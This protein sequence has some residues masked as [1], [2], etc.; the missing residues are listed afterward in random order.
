MNVSFY[1][2]TER[3]SK[4]N[5]QIPIAILVTHDGWVV[6][7]NLPKLKTKLEDWDNSQYRIVPSKRGEPNNLAAEYNLEIDR[8]KSRLSEYWGNSIIQKTKITPDVV[9]DIITG[10]IKDKLVK[11]EPTLILSFDSFIEQN[12]S[13]RAERTITGYNTTK[14]LLE[15]FVDENKID[16]RLSKL[17]MAFYDK[18]RNYCFQDKGYMNN[19]FAKITNNLKAFMSWA[20]D[21]D[22]HQNVIYHKFKANE[23]NIEVIYLTKEELFHLNS[24]E[25][26]IDRLSRA[27]DIYCF[28]C[29]TGLRY[30][31]LANLKP[32]NIFDDHLKIN[33][34]KTRE[35]DQ[36]IPLSK[37]AKQI[38]EKYKY[39]IHYPLP[40]ISSQKLNEYIKDACEEAEINT[41]VTITR[42]SGK[43]KI[44]KTVPKY[45]LLTLHT[46]R[47]TFVT[48]SLVLGMNQMI[49]RGITGH[50]SDSAFRKYVKVA[51]DVK[52]SEVSKYWD[53]I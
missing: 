10:K 19:T 16:E 28:S 6:R 27:R 5:G 31:D 50:K 17:D 47:K 53:N 4:K 2:R 12:K 9:I 18:L 38:L 24:F 32:S 39:T 13:H 26:E 25:F 44:E 51:D 35:S 22:L 36:V 42:Y 23:E 21:R 49:V 20:E 3:I 43:K 45:Q 14:N 11:A 33:V 52:T 15:T 29:F 40:M 1:L 41:P 7:R 8:V 48:N 30:S 37:Y 34:T 46:G